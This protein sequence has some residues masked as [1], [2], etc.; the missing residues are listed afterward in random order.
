[1]SSVSRPDG[2]NTGRAAGVGLVGLSGVL[3]FLALVSSGLVPSLSGIWV[4]LI[5]GILTTI[6]VA[7]FIYISISGRG[8]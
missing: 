8:G 7:L 2:D 3:F 6:S 1:M 4:W 5:A